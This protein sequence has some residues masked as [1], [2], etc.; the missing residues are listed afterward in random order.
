MVK[1]TK[2]KSLTS[3][4]VPKLPE[5]GVADEGGEGEGGD[6]GED[7]DAAD[8]DFEN[9][10]D[11]VDAAANSKTEVE[12]TDTSDF[13]DPLS[14]AM[15]L[16]WS[17]QSQLADGKEPD[18]SKI[19][20]FTL[21]RRIFQLARL[22]F[23]KTRPAKN[24][25]SK[26]T[27]REWRLSTMQHVFKAVFRAS[28]CM[29][30]MDD[31]FVNWR[32]KVSEERRAKELE[33]EAQAQDMWNEMNGWLQDTVNMTSKDDPVAEVSMEAQIYE[34]R[35]ML[36][37]EEA[38]ELEPDVTAQA[39]LLVMSF[40]KMKKELHSLLQ[41]SLHTLEQGEDLKDEITETTENVKMLM[42]KFMGDVDYV[43]NTAE[44]R[45]SA[46]EAPDI[47]D[48]MAKKKERGLKFSNKVL[49][50]I[51]RMADDVIANLDEASTGQARRPKSIASSRGRSSRAGKHSRPIS[52]LSSHTEDPYADW[53]YSEF[54]HVDVAHKACGIDMVSLRTLTEITGF[55]KPPRRGDCPKLN[56][57]LPKPKPS[58][59]RSVSF[60]DQTDPIARSSMRTS[61]HDMFLR[62]S[63]SIMWW[64]T[65]LG[66]SSINVKNLV[67]FRGGG[68]RKLPPLSSQIDV[69]L[70]TRSKVV[71]KSKG[72][73]EET[74]MKSKEEQDLEDGDEV[75]T[76]LNDQGERVKT[77]ESL[78]KE[79][80]TESL[81]SLQQGKTEESLKSLQKGK[82]EDSLKSLKKEKT[83]ESLKSSPRRVLSHPEG[84][85][86]ADVGKL[87]ALR[88]ASPDLNKGGANE[89]S[90]LSKKYGVLQADIGYEDEAQPL[91]GKI[92]STLEKAWQKT[93]LL[94]PTFAG[95]CRGPLN[96]V[97]RKPKKVEAEV[98]EELWAPPARNMLDDRKKQL[99]VS[100][101]LQA[102]RFTKRVPTASGFGAAAQYLV[103]KGRD[104]G[105]GL[106]EKVPRRP[107]QEPVDASTQTDNPPELVDVLVQTDLAVGAD[108][109]QIGLG[110]PPM[111]NRQLADVRTGP[112][113]M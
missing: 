25:T 109:F 7:E 18:D 80:T 61:E 112:R 35:E 105:K 97:R 11:E 3:A 21:V 67:D 87:S 92:M 20:Y 79:K 29:R 99:P 8:F 24:V 22:F 82:T 72:G 36:E 44:Q 23:E 58:G 110:E 59:L 68:T 45:R 103:H 84:P 47:P 43:K 28:R 95:A 90:R 83:E 17:S 89:R 100:M 38:E 10:M 42:A 60:D 34:M 66:G 101:C 48:S 98:E 39:K 81:K 93:R 49:A 1:R 14:D 27:R 5:D 106:M 65:Q 4:Q 54:G 76:R 52:I 108:G 74:R 50:K 53:K 19:R 46:W 51:V 70:S 26:E 113:W 31:L 107:L 57:R 85:L 2:T 91:R 9:F 69:S 37:D 15:L 77:E 63:V 94:P 6:N 104:K 86:G 64:Q 78:Q 40:E 62:E 88:L 102:L 16:D 13:T 96:A 73:E 71:E 32:K 41:H 30:T 12:A 75:V 56:P 33:A 111:P 55:W